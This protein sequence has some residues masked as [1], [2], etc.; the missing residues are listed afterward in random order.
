[1]D[2]TDFEK[3]VAMALDSLPKEIIEKMDNVAVVVEKGVPNGP[4]LGL[5]QGIPKNAW[6]RGSGMVLPDK[7]TI[8]QAPLERKAGQ[9]WKK[10]EKAVREVVF[11]E[12]AHHFGFDE[13]DAERL[14]K[15]AS[16]SN[17]YEK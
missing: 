2:S 17:Q 14:E 6:G 9:D 10:L 11:H 15:K 16:G 5:Y 8:F 12:I 4:Y 3:I 1:M 13:E 7:I